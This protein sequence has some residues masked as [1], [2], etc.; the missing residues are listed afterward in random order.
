MLCNTFS[1]V[2]NILMIW[3]VKSHGPH[4]FVF[5]GKELKQKV[6]EEGIFLPNSPNP[7]PSFQSSINQCVRQLARNVSHK[8]GSN[9]SIRFETVVVW[10]VW[11]FSSGYFWV[12]RAHCSPGRGRSSETVEKNRGRANMVISY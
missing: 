1:A 9:D 12:S 4:P 5:L 2:L 8:C 10:Q 11:K 7:R 3:T 6:T